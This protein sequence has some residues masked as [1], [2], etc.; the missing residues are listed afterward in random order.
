V[1]VVL[2]TLVLG[3]AAARLLWRLVNPRPALPA[4]TPDWRRLAARLVHLAL[5]GV[6]LL[7]PTTGLLT[8]WLAGKEVSVFWIWVVPPL[9][10]PDRALSHTFKEMH[11][12]LGNVLL[13]LVGLHVAAALWHHFI[14]R[15]GVLRQMLRG[16]A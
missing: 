7:L 15:D 1:H 16:L 4:G 10:G 3:F 9:L 5:Y 14:W 11:E 12:P 6:M 8:A 2:G 13:V